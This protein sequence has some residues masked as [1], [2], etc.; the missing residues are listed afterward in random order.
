MLDGQR[1]FKYNR[2]DVL[3]CEDIVKEV[4][5]N[6]NDISAEKKTES[7]G[8]WFQSKNEFCRRK[9]GI[10]CQKSKGKKTVICLGRN[11]V[12]FCFLPMKDE[13]I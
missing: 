7:E 9:K 8:S 6:E 1:Y 13:K 11:L 4:F 2:Y 5:P 3:L 12:A 10:S